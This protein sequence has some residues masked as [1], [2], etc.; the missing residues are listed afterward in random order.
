MGVGVEGVGK[1]K[2]YC[3]FATGPVCQLTISLWPGDQSE[4][5]KI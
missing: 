1:R 5:Q 4:V 3:S 2:D